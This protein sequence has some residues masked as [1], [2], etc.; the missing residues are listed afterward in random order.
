[1]KSSDPKSRE[2]RSIH[3]AHTVGLASLALERVL[4]VVVASVGVLHVARVDTV[5]AHVPK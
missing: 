1:M 4:L 5:A 2:H 3:L